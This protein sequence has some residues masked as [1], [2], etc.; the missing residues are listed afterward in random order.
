MRFR[1][2]QVHY[3]PGLAIHQQSTPSNTCLPEDVPLLLPS[4]IGPD[5]RERTCSAALFDIESQ[6][7]LAQT[8]DAL[9]DLR[10]NLRLRSFTNRFK[11]K[12]ITGQ[13]PN[14]QARDIQKQIDDKV[15]VAAAKYG[16]ARQAYLNLA[17]PGDWERTYRI[18]EQKDIRG[19]HESALTEREAEERRFVEQMTRSHDPDDPGTYD[20]T[21]GSENAGEGRRTLSWIW[22][23]V[24]S[25]VDL[26]DADMDQGEFYGL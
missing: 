6:L 3:M 7:R 8:S 19:L 15:R 2:L 10:Y 23:S 20:P 25:H 1:E 24:G 4:S 22:L 14:T 11:I 12:N 18:L 16:R 5:V 26:E 21:T 9:E 17:G 13:R